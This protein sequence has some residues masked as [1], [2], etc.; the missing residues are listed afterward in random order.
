MALTFPLVS[1]YFLDVVSVDVYHKGVSTG[2]LGIV[3]LLTAFKTGFALQAK[4]S[5]TYLPYKQST[6][7]A[8]FKHKITDFYSWWSP[9]RESTPPPTIKC[10]IF[11]VKR[12]I[13]TQERIQCRH[14][15]H[16]T[17]GERSLF[18]KQIKVFL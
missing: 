3:S 16:A 10:H 1:C 6:D 4:L 7:K 12:L 9:M 17:V 14:Q 8:S 5:G 13:L 2:F 18:K 11:A 15:P